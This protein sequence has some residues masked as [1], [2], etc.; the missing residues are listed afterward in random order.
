MNMEKI[1]KL[2]E[3]DT[4]TVANGLGSLGFSQIKYTTRQWKCA[5]KSKL[6]LTG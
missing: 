5:Q 4:P 2:V 1:K 6:C 3:F